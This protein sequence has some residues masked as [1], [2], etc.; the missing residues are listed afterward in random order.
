MRHRIAIIEHYERLIMRFFPECIL[1]IHLFY[2]EIN[3]K[4]DFHK[5]SNNFEEN[6]VTGGSKK[7]QKSHEVICERPTQV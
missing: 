2:E 4:M 3:K 6:I 1:H 7:V 5:I